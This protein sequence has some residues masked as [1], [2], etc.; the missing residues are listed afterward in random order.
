M[1]D[2]TGPEGQGSYNIYVH[3]PSEDFFKWLFLQQ[4]V[5]EFYFNHAFNLFLVID[6]FF[7]E[8]CDVKAGDGV[9]QSGAG[10][11]VLHSPGQ[12]WICSLGL[13]DPRGMSWSL[14]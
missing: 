2:S 14:S 8:W 5:C 4:E 12:G 7:K 13:C 11:E 6:P 9:V 3:F 10:A 1:F